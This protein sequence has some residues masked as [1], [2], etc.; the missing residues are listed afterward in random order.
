MKVTFLGTSACDFSPR[1]DSDLKYRFDKDVRRSSSMLIDD[2]FLIDCG[3]HTFDA[4]KTAG[5]DRGAI[6]DLFITHLHRD[7]YNPKN[8]I[9]L[10]KE[11]RKTLCVWVSENADTSAL[12]GQNIEIKKTKQ[13]ESYEV[14][15]SFTVT[16]LLANHDPSVYPQ[17]LF[18]IIN[19][20]KVF[21]GC[22][23]AWLF[24]RTYYFLKDKRL[25]LC[26]L[27]CTSGDYDGDFRMG[28]HNS[29]PMLRVMLPSLRT[30]KVIDELSNV[31]FSH[32]A[33]SLHATHEETAKIA[34]EMGANVA[35]DG[36][37]INI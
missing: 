12:D 20:K 11:T 36:L 24:N 22:D 15:A 2:R 1:L 8:I 3:P 27:D 14:N 29:I 13:F 21:Y 16:S 10:S 9:A 37:E 7:H 23:G 28:E 17:H 6:T 25:D 30:F 34:A 4:L 5:K 31:Y 18:F 32:L 33:P 35:Y 19:G 26:V